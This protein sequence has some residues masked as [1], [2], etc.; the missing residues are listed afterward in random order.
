MQVFF[1]PANFFHRQCTAL[2]RSPCLHRAGAPPRFH[3][4]FR[5][6]GKGSRP[7]GLPVPPDWTA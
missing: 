4:L 6:I 7:A 2:L 1:T 5:R 3:A